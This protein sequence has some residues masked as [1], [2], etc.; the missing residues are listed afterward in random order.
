[1]RKIHKNTFLDKAHLW[2]VRTLMGFTVA[3][4]LVV[5]VQFYNYVKNVRPTKLEVW[6]KAKEEEVALEQHE[7]ELELLR[8]QQEAESTITS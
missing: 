7:K 8:R 4:C 3:G 6:R 5:G 1:M 2:S